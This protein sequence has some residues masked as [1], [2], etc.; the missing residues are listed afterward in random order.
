[1][2]YHAV[3]GRLKYKEGLVNESYWAVTNTFL[4]VLFF[5]PFKVA[6]ES[7]NVIPKSASPTINF[8]MKQISVEYVA[9]IL[10]VQ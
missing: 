10:P 6:L 5:M 3:H 7:L 9:E 1:M 4:L 2:N 8:E